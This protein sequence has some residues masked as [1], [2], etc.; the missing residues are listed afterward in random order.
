MDSQ[1]T[2]DDAIKNLWKIFEVLS[3]CL[4]QPPEKVGYGNIFK[5]IDSMSKVLS[6]IDSLGKR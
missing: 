1:K 6:L 4:S 2:I 5:I 3:N